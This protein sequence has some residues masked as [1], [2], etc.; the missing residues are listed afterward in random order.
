MAQMISAGAV[1]VHDSTPAITIMRILGICPANSFNV[2]HNFDGY[3]YRGSIAGANY[4]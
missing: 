4:N 3:C 1:I 2:G